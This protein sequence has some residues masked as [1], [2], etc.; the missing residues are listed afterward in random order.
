ML[1]EQS[2]PKEIDYLYREI[3]NPTLLH[4]SKTKLPLQGNLQF[5]PASA[6]CYLKIV[7]DFIY[8]LYPLLQEKNIVIP[9]YFPPKTDCG[10][11]ISV[12][13]PTEHQAPK[14]YRQLK[15]KKITSL[16]SF[17]IH[18]IF[19]LKIFNKIFYALGVNSAALRQL[20]LDCG[21]STKLNYHGLLIPFHITIAMGS[22]F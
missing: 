14:I 5:D 6:Y 19:Y 22:T 12:L 11:H 15:S 13:Y 18:G 8:K 10:A 4:F 7:D 2:D 21:L 17:E 3:N 20:R 16:F 9:D 1:I